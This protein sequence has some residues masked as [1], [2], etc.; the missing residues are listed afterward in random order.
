MVI[1]FSIVA[2]ESL[3]N[4]G[5]FFFLSVGQFLLPPFVQSQVKPYMT[6]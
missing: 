3:D 5:A 2:V 6:F 4:A 1:P